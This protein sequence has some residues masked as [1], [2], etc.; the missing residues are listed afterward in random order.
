MW[1]CPR[2]FTQLLTEKLPQD[3]TSTSGHDG[4]DGCSMISVPILRALL[5]AGKDWWRY[6]TPADPPTEC[7]AFRLASEL[8][9]EQLWHWWAEQL[10]SLS[11]WSNEGCLA[12]C[13]GT[14]S[15]VWSQFSGERPWGDFATCAMEWLQSTTGREMGNNLTT[16]IVSDHD[17]IQFWTDIL[18]LSHKNVCVCHTSL[19]C[20]YIYPICILYL[21]SW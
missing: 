2:S 8:H 18:V 1:W 14:W 13:Y 4:G 12:V 16:H 19:N 5:R 21:C 11:A 9:A 3:A 20:K 15:F 17:V 6:C 10:W 7:S